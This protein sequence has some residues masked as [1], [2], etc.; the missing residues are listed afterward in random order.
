MADKG[1]GEGIFAGARDYLCVKC[2]W[3]CPRQMEV[4]TEKG[5]NT[6]LGKLVNFDWMSL[7]SIAF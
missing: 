1:D 3:I 2:R 7:V 4:Y 6:V 5:G